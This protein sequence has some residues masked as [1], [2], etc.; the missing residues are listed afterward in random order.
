MGMHARRKLQVLTAAAAVSV[1]ACVPVFAEDQNWEDKAAADVISCANIR[2]E[3][4]IQS[5]R[6]GVLPS[7]AM[8]DV[9][10]RG[11]TW[12]Y[13]ASGEVEGYIRND[14]LVF[15]EEARRLYES[16]HGEDTVTAVSIEDYRGN[17]ASGSV[18]EEAA[19]AVSGSELDLL[20]AIIQCEAGGES[21]EGKVAVGAVV[22]NRVR[23]GQFPDNITDVVYQSGQFSPVASGIL[24]NVLAQGARSDC[25]EAA[26][27]A[28]AGAKPV[29]DCLYFNSGSGQGIQIGN[30]HFY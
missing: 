30:Q 22:L 7:G 29:G 11:E 15:G 12:T 6:L 13:I 10:E 17:S 26:R 14:L 25:Y 9:V 16:A 5:E 20:A 18:Q 19:S 4:T 1:L 28:L 24:S 2:S 27:E 21:H 8:A 3:A 23:S